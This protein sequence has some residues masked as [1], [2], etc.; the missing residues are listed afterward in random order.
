MPVVITMLAANPPVLFEGTVFFMLVEVRG[1]P[2]GGLEVP[3]MI[4]LDATTEGKV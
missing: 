4:N 3:I 2:P 1:I